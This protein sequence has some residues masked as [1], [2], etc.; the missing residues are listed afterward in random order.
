MTVTPA[1]GEVIA[2]GQ[3]AIPGKDAEILYEFSLEQPELVIIEDQFGRVD[4]K[5]NLPNRFCS[6][7]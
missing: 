6:G 1:L 5:D 2:K 4:Y 7:G 3:P